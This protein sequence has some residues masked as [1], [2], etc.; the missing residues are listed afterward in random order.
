MF[1]YQKNIKNENYPLKK[2]IK[3]E[4]LKFIVNQLEK[5]VMEYFRLAIKQ[6]FT[7]YA[8]EKDKEIMNLYHKFSQESI[9]YAS[10]EIV[11]KIELSFPYKKKK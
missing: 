7:A 8:R 6:S 1:E 3:K 5:K 2:D 4:V 9:K 10:K 11:K